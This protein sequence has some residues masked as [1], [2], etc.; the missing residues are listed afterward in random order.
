MRETI[1]VGCCGFPIGLSRYAQSFSVVEVQQTFY[2]PP[3]LSTLE[4]CR[5]KVPGSFEFTLKAWQL[6]THESKSSTYRRLR[7]RLD[8][9]L[10]AE[11]GAFQPTA[12]VT[13]AWQRT[14][15]CARLLGSR[16]IVFQCPA[17]FAPTP[18]NKQSLRR[19]FRG[20]DRALPNELSPTTSQQ[21]EGHVLCV[22]EPRGQWASEGYP[23]TV[24]RVAP[25]SLRR[26]IPATS[27][28]GGCSVLPLARTDGI[29][30]SMHGV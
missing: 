1:K 29:P 13:M 20:I 12:V 30:L 5:K 22:W 4:R 11:A 17:R 7:K 10:R 14:L 18:E 21:G 15:E 3:A 26:P 9:A 6:I 2:Q 16:W 25:G 8:D 24:P 27:G 28:N 23:R 19:F